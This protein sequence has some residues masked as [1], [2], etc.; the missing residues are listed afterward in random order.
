LTPPNPRAIVL[1]DT[2]PPERQRLSLCKGKAER[3]PA[4]HRGSREFYQGKRSR[5]GPD[6]IRDM[7]TGSKWAPIVSL[8]L[9]AR[10]LP[11]LGGHVRKLTRWRP[12]AAWYPRVAHGEQIPLVFDAAYA[13]VSESASGD[14]RIAGTTVTAAPLA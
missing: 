11:A 4:N 13:A 6:G 9:L 12:T 3:E 8:G 7:A 1:D 10:Y 2:R 5:P 14:D